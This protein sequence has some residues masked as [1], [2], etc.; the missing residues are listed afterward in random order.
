MAEVTCTGGSLETDVPPSGGAPA[1]GS[2]ALA[3]VLPPVIPLT[4]AG[5][6]NDGGAASV[7]A[8]VLVPPPLVYIA[9]AIDVGADSVRVVA[10]ENGDYLSL[11][12][13]LPLQTME[14]LPVFTDQVSLILLPP[15]TPEMLPPLAQAGA[16]ATAAAITLPPPVPMPITLLAP[17]ITTPSEVV[18]DA[19]IFAEVA[20]ITLIGEDDTTEITPIP[21]IDPVETVVGLTLLDGSALALMDDD[22]GVVLL[23]PAIFVT[24]GIGAVTLADGSGP[25]LLGDDTQLT[26]LEAA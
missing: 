22:A 23:N 3:I 15:A 20:L 26:L 8:P 5:H 1:G 10:L 6:D 12:L 25:L 21:P 24:D 11:M 18:I 4:V 2:H 14:L 19:P 7:L 13:G 17:R 9:T 16:G